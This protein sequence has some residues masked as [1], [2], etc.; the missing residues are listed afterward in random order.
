MSRPGEDRHATTRLGGVSLLRMLVTMTAIWVMI[1]LYSN[2]RVL[3]PEVIARLAM[4][5]GG[6]AM[7]TDQN[8]RFARLELL[9]YGALPFLLTLRVGSTALVLHLF[10]MLLTTEIGY[11]ELF[12]ASLWGFSAVMYGMSVHTL[13]LALLGPDLTMADLSVVPDSLGALISSPSPTMAYHA[14][15]LLSLHGLLWIGIVFA[16]FRFECCVSKRAAL[17]VPC[18]TWTTISL[19]QLGLKTFTAQ[20]LG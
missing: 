14:L 10:S 12:R 19:A 2:E 13:R 20:I 3:T 7:T 16:Y 15:S 4:G 8:S 9:A 11:R 5:G 1:T 18:A 17:L 6:M